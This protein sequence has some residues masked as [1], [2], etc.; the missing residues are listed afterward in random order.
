MKL[1][2]LIAVRGRFGDCG[3]YHGWLVGLDMNNPANV[4]AGHDAKGAIWGVG[5]IASDGNNPFVTTGNTFNT[6]GT[7]RGGEAAIRFQPGPILLDSPAIT[8]RR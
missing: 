1:S 4:M 5:G 2:L 6:G 3:S 8:G 7:W